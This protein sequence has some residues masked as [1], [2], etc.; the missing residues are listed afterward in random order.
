MFVYNIE[1]V[2]YSAWKYMWDYMAETARKQEQREKIFLEGIT[3]KPNF[4]MWFSARSLSDKGDRAPPFRHLQSSK[5]DCTWQQIWILSATIV[6]LFFQLP[7]LFVP[8]VFCTGLSLCLEIL[9]ILVC[10]YVTFY[11]ITFFFKFI[12]M[13]SNN[14]YVKLHSR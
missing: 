13:Y 2:V 1:R 12:F 4:K 5:G 14:D 3:A 7:S 6:C 11:L 9:L 10:L 8:L